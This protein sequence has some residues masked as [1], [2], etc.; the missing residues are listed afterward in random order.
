MEKEKVNDEDY[1][2]YVKEFKKQELK[3]DKKPIKKQEEVK[4][5]SNIY[6]DSLHLKAL[7]K[8]YPGAEGIINKAVKSWTKTLNNKPFKEN[9]KEIYLQEIKDN[10]IFIN[11]DYQEEE[12]PIKFNEKEF[13][14]FGKE[15]Y[16]GIIKILKTYVDMNELYYPIV[17]SWIM[18][19]YLHDKMITFPYL[20][21]NAT[22]GSGK[23]RVTRLIT[24]LSWKGEIVNSMTEAVLFRSKGTLGIDEFE[25]IGRKG[26]ENFTELLNSAYK[27]GVKVKRIKTLKTPEGE[28]RVVE[29][30]D[31]FRPIILA[32]IWG[33]DS[34]LGD[35]A[36]P[37][38]LE[39]TTRS[40][41]GKLLEIFEIDTEIK[42]IK[43]KIDNWCSLCSVVSLDSVYLEWNKYIIEGT[44]SVNTSHTYNYTKLHLFNQINETGIDGRM[45]EL[46]LP[47]FL[48]GDLISEETFQEVKNSLMII[49][50]E[51]KKE[52][53]VENKDIFLVDMISQNLEKNY[54][55]SVREITQELKDFTGINDDWLNE[56]WV[57]RA[58]KRLQLTIERKRTN[59]GI[60]V[61]LDYNKAKE[62]IRMFN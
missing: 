3:K 53:F 15:C 21:F 4:H 2:N 47:L 26:T 45:L 24:H 19:T 60:E 7:I 23:T 29:D 18:G 42:D 36:L 57:G 17:S 49:C 32:N 1:N 9:S 56:K 12:K 27:R 11:L 58:L 44:L 31:V 5:I 55:Q 52:E 46:S 22:K 38:F 43:D 61:I 33:M 59:R 39:K 6:I 37:L 51:K 54:Y 8:K 40:E 28:E 50:D 13:K 30:F 48:V 20:Y 10:L 35:R 34:V 41:I 25:G 62:K 16:D 14:E